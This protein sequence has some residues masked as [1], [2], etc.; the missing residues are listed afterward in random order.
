MV[1]A[2]EGV[3]RNEKRGADEA[4]GPSNSKKSKLTT[5]TSSYPANFSQ[6]NT[7]MPEEDLRAR[8]PKYVDARSRRIEVTLKAG[9]M[10]YLPAGWFHEVRSSAETG[11]GHMALN[12]WFHPPDAL[13]SFDRPYS[14]DFWKQ[15]WDLNM[16]KP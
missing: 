5:A 16:N 4:A 11:S 3:L 14:T 7:S 12:Y 1:A 6:V 15:D 13:S 10:L 8:F 9:E 2:I